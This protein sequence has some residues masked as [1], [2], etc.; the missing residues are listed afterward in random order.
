MLC[1]ELSSQ[2]LHSG[3]ISQVKLYLRPGAGRVFLK[4]SD[5]SNYKLIYEQQA[6]YP[7]RLQTLEAQYASSVKFHPHLSKHSTVE[8]FLCALCLVYPRLI[9]SSNDLYI[10]IDQEEFP[11]LDGSI[12]LW[13]E[14]F[15]RLLGIK[16]PL[17]KV[18]PQDLGL[19]F[20]LEVHYGSK[21][22]RWSIECPIPLQN[23]LEA[24]TFT[25]WSQYESLVN[26]HLLKGAE[27][28]H[29]LVF[30]QQSNRYRELTWS[31]SKESIMSV[32]DEL[33]YHK[34]VDFI[35]DLAIL[36]LKLPC[37]PLKIK[38]GGHYEHHQILKG[39]SH[40]ITRDITQSR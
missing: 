6:Q 9:E 35:G 30:Q 31:S 7:G 12:L 1:E 25:T 29:A 13:I 22:V 40:D 8:H 38:D 26:S 16:I 18:T 28:C 36:S 2:A 4:T 5:A 24:R 37:K 11:I 33:C 19:N 34:M 23:L 32:E 10:L 15:E 14:A 21:N 27:P 17:H 20:D 39:L 3:G